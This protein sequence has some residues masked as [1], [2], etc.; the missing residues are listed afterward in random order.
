M[1][2]Q[3]PPIS[4]PK[5]PAP[6]N[7]TSKNYKVVQFNKKIKSNVKGKKKVPRANSTAHSQR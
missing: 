5:A 6:T 3:K 1:N 7:E 2:N 4:I